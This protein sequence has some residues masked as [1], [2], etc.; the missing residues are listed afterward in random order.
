[1]TQVV[2]YLVDAFFAFS[3]SL[4]LFFASITEELTLETVH[5]AQVNAEVRAVIKGHHVFNE[6]H[7]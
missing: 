6:S 7:L 3:K 4:L 5:H 2:E 1:M